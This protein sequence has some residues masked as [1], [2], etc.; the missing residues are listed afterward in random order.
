MP[1]KIS[2]LTPSL[3]I[4]ANDLLQ[5]IDVDDG[6]MGASGT[7]RSVTAGVAANEIADLITSVPSIVAT[8]LSTKA[9]IN[10]PTFLGTVT[11]PTTTSIGPVNSAEIGRLSGV[12]SN[13]QTQLNSKLST[14]S[15]SFSNTAV[16]SN[17][18]ANSLTV[19]ALHCNATG[20]AILIDDGGHKRI[21]WNDGDGN[22]NIRSGHYR[23]STATVFAKAPGDSNGGAARITM[24]TDTA[25]GTITISTAAVGTPG[26]AVTWANNFVLTKD[27]AYTDKKFGIGTST[28]PTAFLQIDGGSQG[29]CT[30]IGG[31]I[32]GLLC[33][34][35]ADIELCKFTT[36]NS[37][38]SNLIIDVR[39]HSAGTTWTSSS[40]RI[41]HVTDVT[42]QGYIEFNPKDVPHGLALGSG[43]TAAIVIKSDG[44]VGIGKSNPATA[45]D[46]NGTVTAT[47]F[48]GSFDGSITGNSAT[49]TLAGKASTLA[50]GGANGSGMTFN[51]VGKGGTPAWLWGGD[52]ISN[53]YVYTPGNLSVGYA[54]SAGSASTANSLTGLYSLKSGAL[55]MRS[56]WDNRGT[57]S[58]TRVL[59]G[60]YYNYT[61]NY[62]ASN[63]TLKSA[64]EKIEVDHWVPVYIPNFLYSGAYKVISND[65]V[66]KTLTFRVKHTSLLTGWTTPN[67]GTGNSGTNLTP[68]GI[69]ADPWNRFI[70]M[71][72]TLVSDTA[73]A[74]FLRSDDDGML[75][76]IN[77]KTG[78]QLP[79]A[80]KSRLTIA[81]HYG[82]YAT[83]VYYTGLLPTT[84][85]QL[86][87]FNGSTN[88]SRGDSEWFNLVYT[89]ANSDDNYVFTNKTIP[90]GISTAPRYT[91]FEIE[92][93][94][95]PYP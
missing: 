76:F 39:R 44:K 63:A 42:A 46:V 19:G 62:S 83:N 14:S 22:L 13:I 24:N 94:T 61:L 41:R 90:I 31:G 29:A 11:L 92:Y 74:G 32:E 89:S 75:C 15:P 54:A 25:D 49:S 35:T 77:L 81:S 71:H 86:D 43:S 58:W 3:S 69:V 9:D 12:T 73:N 48:S 2:E 6:T 87:Y 45:L 78:Y 40:T 68:F 30:P 65:V 80:E 85:R 66:N 55:D 93:I 37:N 64:C 56:T 53:M 36:T 60:S 1:F 50:S 5:I 7:N 33:P 26:T 70:V 59:S 82:D 21:S 18:S 51:W 67:V 57:V 91:H 79:G 23:T 27:A 72:S 17:S 95:V 20:G 84:N 28:A 34:I 52:N 4:T 88:R 16:F 47:S 10:G 8:A 38:A